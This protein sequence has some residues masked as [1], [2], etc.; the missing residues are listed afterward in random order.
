[1][2]WVSMVPSG[3]STPQ[4]WSALWRLLEGADRAG[5]ELAALGGGAGG[6]D[7]ELLRRIVELLAA[8]GGDDGLL[9]AVGRRLEEETTAIRATLRPPPAVRPGDVLA[10]RFEL[11]RELGSGG[12]GTVFTAV[13]RE[14]ATAIA[15]KVLRPEVAESREARG[16]FRRELQLARRVTHPNV[17]RLFDLFRA[18]RDVLFLTMELLAGETLAERLER[19]SLPP[20]EARAIARDVAAGLAAVHRAGVVHRDLK[21]GNVML[22]ADGDRC[23]VVTDFGLAT[24]RDAPSR[25]TMSGALMGTPAYMAPEQLQGEPATP[26]TDVYALGLLL[27]QMLTG[28]LPFV[29][30]N[31]WLAALQRVAELVPSPR[32][33]LPSLDPRW[34][35]AILRALEREP[36]RR[37]GGPGELVAALA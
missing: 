26:A 3:D 6:D 23:A 33:Y 30:A 8:G 21:S 17:C 37:H 1:M 27:Y 29:A 36:E 22:L 13:D 16:R 18:E 14:L 35:R 11:V 24:S 12:M 32:R 19:G 2:V 31:P 7:D 5:G 34:E 10:G 28:R 20:L 15:L 4:R 25:L 9:A